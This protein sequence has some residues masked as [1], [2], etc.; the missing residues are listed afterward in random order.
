MRTRARGKMAAALVVSAAVGCDI[1]RPPATPQRPSGL[2]P[3]VPTSAVDDAALLPDEET[4]D[5]LCEAAL[6]ALQEDG[7]RAAFAKMREVSPL[8]AS[9]FDALEAMT[10]QQLD[11]VRPRFGEIIGYERVSVRKLS[12]SV[13]ECIY[14]AKF[15]RHALRWRFYFYRPRDKWLLN[16]VKWDDKIGDL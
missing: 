1:A 9:E 8:P 7:V 12:A 2:G 6:K 11:T 3:V 10:E 15:E 5:A 13:I 16:S 4:A 14:L